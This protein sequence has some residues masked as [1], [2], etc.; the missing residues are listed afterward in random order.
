M[1]EQTSSDP[2][3]VQEAKPAFTPL[4]IG[5]YLGVFKGVEDAPVKPQKAD[6]TGERWRFSWEVQ[7]GEHKGKAATALTDRSISPTAL[8][9]VL[10]SGLLGR[11]LIAGE[12]VKDAI[13][14]CKGKSYMVSIQ[15]GPKG[16]KPQVRAVSQPP[17]M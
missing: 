2:W 12:S 1:S 13:D 3:I 15:A 4:P 5:F 17:Q 8:P 9:G 6:D 16:G 14:S 7:S 10:I 11:P